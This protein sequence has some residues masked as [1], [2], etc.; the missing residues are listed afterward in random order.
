MGKWFLM[1]HNNLAEG[2]SKRHLFE[3]LVL[4]RLL[5]T[6][7]SISYE[8]S[9]IPINHS[10]YH[11]L[12]SIHLLFLKLSLLFSDGSESSTTERSASLKLLL[13]I[14]ISRSEFEPC[15]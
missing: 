7:R 4:P 6:C 5:R 8:S 2:D 1:I 10:S 9:C 11:S 14:R 12:I 15:R 13:P 3:K